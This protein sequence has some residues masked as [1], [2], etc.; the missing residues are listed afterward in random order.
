MRAGHVCILTNTPAGVLYIGV[1][2]DL[3]G[4]LEQHRSRAVSG[5][6]KSY[7]CH[8]L[9]WFE[10]FDDIHDARLFERRM[11]KWNRAWKIAR[12]VERNPHWCDLADSIG[13]V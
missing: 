13:H 5:F 10:T 6:S 3:A 11:K 2:G 1:T 7:N 12:I 8:R 4:R 9:V